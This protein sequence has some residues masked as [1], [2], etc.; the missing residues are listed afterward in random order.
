[1][2]GYFSR[3][4]Y[5][6]CNNK[7]S[8]GI[9]TKPG[10]WVFDTLQEHQEGCFSK[11]GPRNTRGMATSQVGIRYTDT[12]D[13]ENS[14]RGSDIPLSRCMGLNTLQERDEKLNKLYTAIP[15]KEII[16][17]SNNMDYNYTRLEPRLNLVEQS[18]NRYGYPIID[19]LEFVYNGFEQYG[20]DKNNREGVS[21]RF[22]S[23]AKLEEANKKLREQSRKFTDIK[24]ANS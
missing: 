4:L 22:N 19:P 3:S 20:M 12:I 6:E 13:I 15:K 5:D 1:M 23:K 10:Q 18:F 8:I 16:S 2:S 9:S 11:N 21:T 7:E 14:L 17:C 24:P